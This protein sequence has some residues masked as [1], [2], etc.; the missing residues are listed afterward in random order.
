[1]T[2]TKEDLNTF[3]TWIIFWA[4]RGPSN[5]KWGPL[6][7]FSV[8]TF[9]NFLKSNSTYPSFVPISPQVYCKVTKIILPRPTK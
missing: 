1:V 7:T 2:V 4:N 9:P 8:V 5:K 3:E 6:R